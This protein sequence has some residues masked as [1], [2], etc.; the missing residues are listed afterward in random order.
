MRQPSI[1]SVLLLMDILLLSPLL[2]HASSFIGT[3]VK[4]TDGDTIQVMQDGKAEKIRLA[5]IDCPEKNQAFG[6]AAKRFTLSL[7]AQK[8]VTV[9]VDTKDRYR[10]SIAEVILPDGRSLNHEL[11][12]AGYAWWYR[13]HS[14]DAVLG[15]L[16]SEARRAQRGL[17]AA[18]SPIPP[19]EWRQRNREATLLVTSVDSLS[20]DSSECEKKHYCTQMSSCE[21]ARFFLEQ[22]GAASLDRDSDGVPC[23]SLCQ[24]Y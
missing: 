3:V 18:P 21:E 19:W 5:G 22:C 12:R 9:R 13:R 1:R 10:R 20:P 6:N 14:S 16:E 11:V 4:V 17:W 23:E 8:V 15:F 7:I 24:Q 2:A